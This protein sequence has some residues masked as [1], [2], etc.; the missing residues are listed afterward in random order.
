M[1]SLFFFNDTATTEIYTLSLH[2]ALPI[3]QAFP[4]GGHG[5]AVASRLLAMRRPDQFVCLDSANRARLCGDFGITQN[6]MDYAR[7]WEE[8]I[9]R[10]RDAPWWNAKRPA[11][12][13]Q[14][15]VWDGRVAMLDTIFYD[16]G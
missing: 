8:I 7:Y 1:C 16:H 15:A 10:I 13:I 14:A 3:L 4:N 12:R 2:D 6:G 5:A 9:E 11:D